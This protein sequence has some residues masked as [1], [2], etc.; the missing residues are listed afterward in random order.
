MPGVVFDLDGLLLD[1][2]ELHYR[3]YN[4]VLRRF[5]VE[6][7]RREYALHWIGEGHGPEYAVEHYRLP[8]SPAELRAAKAPIYSELLAREAELMPGARAALARLAPQARLAIA[9][10][11][12]RRDVDFVLRRFSLEGWFFAVVVREDYIHA[13][14]APDAYREAVKRL[15]V[16]AGEVLV[17]EDSPRGVRAAQA[18]GL[19]VLA[20]P[21]A[22]TRYCTFPDAVEQLACLEE[23]TW[24]RVCRCLAAGSASR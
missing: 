22:F 8:I 4:A 18:A 7:D 1:S 2:E 15:G 13:K 16:P 14:P 9:T 19:A 12:S 21:N 6:V 23:L 10:N 17:V 24:E 20:V 5:G 3:A 11:S